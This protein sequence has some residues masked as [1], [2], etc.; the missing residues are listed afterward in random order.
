MSDIKDL[1]QQLCSLLWLA[2]QVMCKSGS[3]ALCTAAACFAVRI[4]AGHNIRTDLDR[5]QR[6]VMNVASSDLRLERHCSSSGSES[7]PAYNQPNKLIV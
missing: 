4:Y 5:Q 1:R 3:R 6:Y 7:L 2:Q